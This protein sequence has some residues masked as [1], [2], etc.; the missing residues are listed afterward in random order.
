MAVQAVPS[1]ATRVVR[2]DGTGA[3]VVEADICVLGAGIAGISAALTAARLGRRVILADTLP[4]L[5]G[6]AYASVENLFDTGYQNP[7][8][9]SVRNLPV[10]AFGRTMTFG[11]R[12]TF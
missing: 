5:G 1:T 8:A 3:T 6:Q 4:V 11:Y 2:R 7:T 9:T 12:K 10:E